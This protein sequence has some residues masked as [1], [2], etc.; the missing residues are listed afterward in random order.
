MK[1]VLREEDSVPVECNYR[2]GLAVRAGRPGRPTHRHV[3]R[4]LDIHR[5]RDIHR[6]FDCNRQSHRHG[7]RYRDRNRAA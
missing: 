6:D 2:D 5:Y 3:H 1:G 4:Y 7:D